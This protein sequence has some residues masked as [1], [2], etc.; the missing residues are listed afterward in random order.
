MSDDTACGY[1]DIDAVIADTD[2]DSLYSDEDSDDDDNGE[3]GD[4]PEARI[5]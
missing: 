3:G 5:C 4:G 2:I 1:E